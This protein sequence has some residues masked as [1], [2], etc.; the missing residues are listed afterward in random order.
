[1]KSKLVLSIVIIGTLLVAGACSAVN[2]NESLD[3]AS[4]EVTIE[5]L[6]DQNHIE[7]HVEVAAGSTLKVTLG[8]NPTTG[9]K[10]TE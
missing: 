1:M 2:A 7:K 9:F 4:I 6:M 8:S 10:W 3:Q 5:E